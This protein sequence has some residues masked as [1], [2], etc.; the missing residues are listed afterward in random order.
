MTSL[1]SSRN[2]QCQTAQVIDDVL[3]RILGQEATQLLYKYLESKYL[4]QKHE[5]AEK[6]DSFNCALENYLGAGAI[7]IE[8]V[9]MQNLEVRAPEENK[10]LHLVEPPIY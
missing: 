2:K 3:N 6:L 10:H 7:I 5:I 4:I 9:I 1:S 8:K